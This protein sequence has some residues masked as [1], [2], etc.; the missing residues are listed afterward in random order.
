MDQVV[1]G[2]VGRRCCHGGLPAVVVMGR[3]SHGPT[4]HGAAGRRLARTGGRA[5]IR[6]GTVE[7]VGSGGE[8]IEAGEDR[9][10]VVRLG[11][12]TCPVQV[13]LGHRL[14]V[15]ILRRRTSGGPR[16]QRPGAPHDRAD[17]LLE[18][19]RAVECRTAA[20]CRPGTGAADRW[21]DRSSTTRRSFPRPPWHRRTVRDARAGSAP[22]RRPRPRRPRAR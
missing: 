18:L 6:L 1:G 3:G 19:D 10:E 21:R 9:D 5:C 13:R 17:R 16:D 11:L 7:R 14:L 15:G 22:Q 4:I 2:Q 20:R 8:A 12:H